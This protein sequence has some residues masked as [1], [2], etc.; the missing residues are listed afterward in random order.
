MKVMRRDGSARPRLVLITLGDIF[1]IEGAVG[2]PWNPAKGQARGYV[3]HDQ[4]AV[5]RVGQGDSTLAYA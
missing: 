4:E 2:Q 3:F 1:S 5:T